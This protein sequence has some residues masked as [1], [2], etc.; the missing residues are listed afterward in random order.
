M[1]AIAQ[2]A[3]K[4]ASEC[5]LT[6]KAQLLQE[7]TM[8]FS[9][10]RKQLYE[11][12][13]ELIV[14][15]K[16]IRDKAYTAIQQNL[17]ET[18]TQLDAKNETE[19]DNAA[20]ETAD[21]LAAL[22]QR[23]NEELA[24]TIISYETTIERLLPRAD[25][26]NLSIVILFFFQLRFASADRGKA[27]TNHRAHFVA[28]RLALTIRTVCFSLTCFLHLFAGTEIHGTNKRIT[29][30]MTYTHTN[31]EVVILM[32][33]MIEHD[34]ILETYRIFCCL[35]FDISDLPVGV[36]GNDQFVP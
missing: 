13:A 25:I 10:K 29:A 7:F 11:R 6:V 9:S 30:L 1:E 31:L 4:I 33:R 8:L 21:L 3:K 32:L 16:A 12:L 26:E 5:S 15:G 20:T 18:K 27:L 14:E 23:H 2:E 22:E 28:H 36:P 17:T 35:W 34:T 19:I 24:S